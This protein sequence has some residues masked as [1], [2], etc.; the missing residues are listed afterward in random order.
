MNEIRT[1]K[2]NNSFLIFVTQLLEKVAKFT[3]FLGHWH[4]QQFLEIIEGYRLKL[5]SELMGISLFTD[6]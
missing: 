4:I 1:A 6:A 2:F 5:I 3:H